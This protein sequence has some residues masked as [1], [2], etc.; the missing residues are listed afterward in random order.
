MKLRRH[1]AAL[2]DADLAIGCDPDYAKAYLR[3]AAAHQA[4]PG[5][6]DH[7]E[8]ALR[9]LEKVGCRS[10]AQSRFPEL[11]VLSSDTPCTAGAH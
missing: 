1:E 7:C 2:A 10:E 11:C 8:A 6:L 9:D 3:R 5:D 4:F